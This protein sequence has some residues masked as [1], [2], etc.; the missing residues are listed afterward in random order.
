MRAVGIE[1]RAP[2]QLDRSR[3]QGYRQPFY[4]KAELFSVESRDAARNSH[5]HAGIVQDFGSRQIVAEDQTDVSLDFHR[6]K[7]P[8]DTKFH[9]PRRR[10]KYVPG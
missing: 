8:L 2:D 5:D 7:I 4:G 3:G 9:V 10:E 1:A 6:A